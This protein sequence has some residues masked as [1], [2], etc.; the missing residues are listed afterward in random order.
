MVSRPYIARLTQSELMACMVA[1]FATT[2]GGVL[3]AYVALLGAFVPGIA[4]PLI[5]CS[6]MRAADSLVVAKVMLPET[7]TPETPGPRPKGGNFR[8]RQLCVCCTRCAGPW[9]GRRPN[10]CLRCSQGF[11]PSVFIRRM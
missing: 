1:G 8:S 6:M 5:A 7:G 3:A 4:G 10:R 2:A 9:K 11:A